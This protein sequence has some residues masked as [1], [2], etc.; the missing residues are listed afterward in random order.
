MKQGKEGF[1]KRV[2][3][4]ITNFDKY[5]DYADD[6]L[7]IT[8]KYILKLVLIFAI[9]TTITVTIKINNVVA[10]IVQVFKNDCPE[11]KIES[12]NLVIE[13]ENKHFINKDDYNFFSFVINSEKDSL[14]G[15]E[16]IEGCQTVFAILK[17]KIIVRNSSIMETSMTY[18][19]IGEEND[20]SIINKQTIVDFTNTKNIVAIISMFA[21]ISVIS[22]FI[23]YLIEIMLDILL[24]SIIGL[25]FSKIIGINFK[26]K[27]IFNMSA[28]AMT[29]PFVL[30]TI[31]MVVNISTGFVIKYFDMAY[32][33]IS[34]IYIITAM[35]M[36]KA[37]LTKEKMEVGKII[38]EQRKIR[39]EN[40]EEQKKEKE[41]K[42][43]NKQ[44]EEK[45][46]NKKEE[47]GQGE[48]PEGSNA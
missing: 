25:L 47:N 22:L 11:F 41:E 32:N 46:E 48:T 8:M 18:A 12:N 42:K 33:A 28:Y 40:K 23:L 9:I 35:M 16:E 43:D 10:N 5:R 37:D 20:L 13:A 31:Y 6:K 14:E 2:K 17:D 24:L 4:A 19:Q 30:Y 38:Q 44:K 21:L 34:Y 26:Y 27:Q 1:F 29:L 45:G 3:N 39:E 15:I 36:I 7:S